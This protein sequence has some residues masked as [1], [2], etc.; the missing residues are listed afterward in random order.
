MIDPVNRTEELKDEDSE[1]DH[2]ASNYTF[3]EFDNQSIPQPTLYN[4]GNESINST[5]ESDTEGYFYKVC[6]VLFSNII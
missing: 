3:G 4:C 5:E 6:K 2:L 1:N